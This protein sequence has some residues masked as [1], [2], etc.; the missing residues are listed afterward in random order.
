MEMFV[1]DKAMNAFNRLSNRHHLK[2]KI[3]ATNCLTGNDL[4]LLADLPEYFPTRGLPDHYHYIGPITLKTT[5]PPPPWWPPKKQGRPVVYVTMGTTGLGEFF[6]RAHALMKGSDYVAVMTTGGQAEDMRTLD[7]KIY[8]ENFM[9]GDLVME[10]CDV[11]VCHGGN[12]TIYQALQHGKPVIAIPTLPDQQY[13]ARRVDA[14]GF[15]LSI[16]W[17]DFCS[18]SGVLLTAIQRVLETPSFTQS[19]CRLQSALKKY[20][21]ETKGANLIES[22]L[23]G[24]IKDCCD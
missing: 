20:D 6:R 19:A 16:R 8:V 2:R 18:D 9:D 1:F 21:A 23:A 5:V 7:G 4:T 15:G 22:L 24:S 13:N 10:A 17:R 12:G 14:L 11:V 3:T